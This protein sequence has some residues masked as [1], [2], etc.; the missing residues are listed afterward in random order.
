M[1]WQ[2]R[3]VIL[4]F[5]SAALPLR[6]YAQ[7]IPDTSLRGE[8]SRVTPSSVGNL[9]EGGAIRDTTLF[10]SFT[11]F[12]V[13]N[14]QQVYFANPNG[15]ANIFTRVTGSNT[16]QILGKL[17]VLGR[18][19]LFLINPNGII[20]GA[21]AQL[22]VAGSFAATTAKS[23]IFD[24]Y[25]FS[26]TNPTAPPLLKINVTPGLQY[27]SVEP[28]SQIRSEGILS[29]GQDLNL[30]GD[31]LNLQGQLLARNDLTLVG[32]NT[33]S[34]NSLHILAGG[35]VN[36]NQITITGAD[37]TGNSINPTATPTLAN[38]NLSD[39]TFFVINGTARP[40]LDIR[41]GITAVVTPG[42][43]GSNYTNLTPV[44]NTSAAT[45]ANITIGSITVT[46]PNALVLLTNQYHPNALS[47]GN[48]QVNS[49][50]TSSN[51]GRGGDILLDSRNNI[52]LTPSGLLSSNSRAG[53]SGNITLIANNAI[54]V[55]N[56]AAITSNILDSNSFRNGGNININTRFL[57]L[58]RGAQ[59]EANVFGNGDGGTLAVKAQQVELMGR[60][61]DGRLRSGLFSRLNSGATGRAGNLIVETD[62]LVV[63]NG[64]Q[65]STSTFGNG[66]G[67]TLA[68]K[69]KLVELIGTSADGQ[70][71]SSLLAGLTQGATGKAGNLTVET[72]RL[73]V[74]DG[75]QVST[76]NF[77]N[78]EGGTLAV[79]AKLVELIGTSAYGQ[80]NS[81]LF[82]RLNPSATGRAGNLTVET[83]RLVVRDGAEIS[84][85]SFRSGTAGNITINTSQLLM[86]DRAIIRS[87][88]PSA[89][90]G[91]NIT[92]AGLNLLL[93]RN[94][95]LI[96]TRATD[97]SP[98]DGGNISINARFIVAV[99]KENSNI[100]A[101]ASI[102]RGGNINITTNGIY[103]LNL[104]NRLTPK[105]DITASSSYGI[106]GRLDLNILNTDPSR[107]L[108][109]LPFALTDASN[110]IRAGCPSDRDARLVFTGRGGLPED[111]RGTLRGTVVMQ[112]LRASAGDS[113]AH[114]TRTT[115]KH[116]TGNSQLPIIE[117]QGWIINQQGQIELVAHLPQQSH[118]S[119]MDKIDCTKLK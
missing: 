25:Q 46:T 23:V 63:R 85:T 35:A 96:T 21:N 61:A 28:K 119:M 52:I 93:L 38:V 97:Q 86:S 5:F 48:I 58:N 54:S 117:A 22:D 95:S 99:P 36:I 107:G 69:A 78:G 50:N 31:E 1:Y 37:T 45:S 111:P 90:N 49:I 66:D 75:A 114:E 33:S 105:S 42:T 55:G 106:N 18:A 68:V 91:G 14:G 71:S 53:N 76:S 57:T 51:V 102:G 59:I 64:A 89:G 60:S 43:S 88:N 101:T 73:I 118:N 41:A 34:G 39:G 6:A 115:Q 100:S 24:N 74:R 72:D 65:I 44:E 116:K 29:V 3:L 108:I 9:I 67:G 87:A 15:I 112:D 79:K 27:G 103:G 19:N 12:N 113:V 30:I 109:E 98:G 94:N 92:L 8:S 7:L 11:E 20:F 70:F 62:R 13:N 77:G 82:A 104:Q 83:D 17:G 81:G 84:T 32:S 16:S 2:L 80:S 56:Q 110:Q 40:T 26:A 4:L 47:T 10:H